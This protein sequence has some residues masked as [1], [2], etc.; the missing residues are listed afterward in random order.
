MLV[1]RIFRGGPEPQNEAL[2]CKGFRKFKSRARMI[3]DTNS[4]LE[5]LNQRD[6]GIQWLGF[7]AYI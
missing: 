2:L 3:Q 6:W 1:S 7:D 4:I 5:A